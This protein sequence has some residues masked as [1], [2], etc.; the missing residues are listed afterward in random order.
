MGSAP[1]AGGGGGAVLPEISFLEP[2]AE[3]A[4]EKRQFESDRLTRWFGG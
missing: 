1:T 3:R 4:A 2:S